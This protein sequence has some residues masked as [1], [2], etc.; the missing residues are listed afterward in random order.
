[1]G[2]NS[3]FKGLNIQMIYCIPFLF[4]SNATHE[5]TPSHFL[6]NALWLVDFHLFKYFIQGNIIFY[7]CPY[8]Q[9]H[10]YGANKTLM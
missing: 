1:M 9:E 2:F 5:F 7:L 4:C 10:N 8:F 3:V 6:L